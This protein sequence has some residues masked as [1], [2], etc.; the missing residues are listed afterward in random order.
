MSMNTTQC[1]KV[2]RQDGTVPDWVIQMTGFEDVHALTPTRI[3]G[4]ETIRTEV[5]VP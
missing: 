1:W 3:L 2:R 5:K 4:F